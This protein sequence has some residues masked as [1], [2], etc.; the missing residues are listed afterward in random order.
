MDERGTE[1][2]TMK[3][4]EVE[5]DCQGG[6]TAHTHTIVVGAGEEPIYNASP[7][8]NVRLQ[9]TCPQSGQA[10]IAIFKPPVGASRPFSVTKVR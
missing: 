2:P 8:S 10:L 1:G 3:S 7:S 9:Y 4:F 5:V 6:G